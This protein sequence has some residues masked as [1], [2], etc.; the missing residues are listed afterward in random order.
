MKSAILYYTPSPTP[1]EKSL[2]QLC[3]VQALR[4]RTVETADLDRRV[5]ALAQGL[6]PS[7]PSPSGV[8][9]GE[10]VLVLCGLSSG[11]LDRLLAAL[12]RMGAGGCLKAVLTDHNAQWTFRALYGELVKERLQLS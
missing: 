5:D 11:Q 12:K 3:A 2:R 4:L 1:W 10:P 9:L 8:P 7:A 6:G